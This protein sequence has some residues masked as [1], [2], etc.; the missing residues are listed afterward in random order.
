MRKETR[1]IYKAE[2]TDTGN[3][4][5]GDYVSFVVVAKDKVEALNLCCK[6]AGEFYR[7]KLSIQEVKTGESVIVSSSF[8][9]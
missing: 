8:Y 9:G 2:R 1:N 7:G 3:I 4:D 5:H 6:Q